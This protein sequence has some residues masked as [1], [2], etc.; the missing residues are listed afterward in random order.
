MIDALA[1]IGSLKTLKQ[2]VNHTK[3]FETAMQ[4]VMHLGRSDTSDVNI[5]LAKSSSKYRSNNE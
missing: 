3:A 2:N 1:K 5:S 4:D